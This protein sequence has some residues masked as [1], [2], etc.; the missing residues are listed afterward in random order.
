MPLHYAIS[1][2]LR[3][4]ETDPSNMWTLMR[5]AGIKGLPRDRDY[6]VTNG[7]TRQFISRQFILR[8]F[9]MRQVTVVAQL[10][11]GLGLGYNKRISIRQ[12]P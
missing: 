1:F 5:P 10:R 6:K 9:I 12:S 7:G 2:T 4:Y 3:R 11:L 8:P